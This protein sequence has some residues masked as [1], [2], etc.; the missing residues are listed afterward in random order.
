[1]LSLSDVYRDV[2]AYYSEELGKR[3]DMN[4]QFVTSVCARI[5]VGAN[6]CKYRVHKAACKFL[7]CVI[8]T[9]ISALVLMNESMILLVK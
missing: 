3:D 8:D 5:T 2:E 9:C 6:P 1:M 7:N 4:K